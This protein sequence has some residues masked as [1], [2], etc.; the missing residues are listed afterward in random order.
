MVQTANTA[1]DKALDAMRDATA[2]I[3]PAKQALA[4][5]PG[6]EK[7]TANVSN[8]ASDFLARLQRNMEAFTKAQQVPDT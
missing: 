6:I 7:A 3:L 8:A 5:A 1:A 4:I 2:K